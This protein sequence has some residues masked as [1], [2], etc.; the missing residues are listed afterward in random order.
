MVI[1]QLPPWYWSNRL[2]AAY[3]RRKVSVWILDNYWEKFWE[4]WEKLESGRSVEKC[5]CFETPAFS[6]KSGSRQSHLKTP[7]LPVPQNR[8]FSRKSFTLLE[9]RFF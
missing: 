1:R 8:A 7:A 4:A 5:L 2:T 9:P 3:N 6:R